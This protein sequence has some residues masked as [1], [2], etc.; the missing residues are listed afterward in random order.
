M[1]EWHHSFGIDQQGGKG[2]AGC[3]QDVCPTIC[4]DSHGTPH[5]VVYVVDP[6][7]SNSMKSRNPHSGF[8]REHIAPCI[9]TSCQSPIRNGGGTIIV[10]RC[11][12]EPSGN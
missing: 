8:H 6:L 5:A 12:R 11:H 1:I 3:G 9:D 10:Q 7:K 4:S 2:M